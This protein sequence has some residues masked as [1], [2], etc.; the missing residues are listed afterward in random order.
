V[1]V[2]VWSQGLSWSG[3]QTQR[4]PALYV[5]SARRKKG[6]KFLL[7]SASQRPRAEPRNTDEDEADFVQTLLL[8]DSGGGAE[9]DQRG[10]RHAQRGRK[11]GK[12]GG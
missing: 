11:Q 3:K 12:C 7:L 8:G 10:P 9:L 6:G 1:C 4:Q 5:L 2:C